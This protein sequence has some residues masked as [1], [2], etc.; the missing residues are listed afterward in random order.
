M[1]SNINDRCQKSVCGNNSN[2][3]SRVPRLRVG[4]RAY[5]ATEAGIFTFVIASKPAE[6]PTQ[7]LFQSNRGSFRRTNAEE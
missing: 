2:S 6:W 1:Y 4:D 7:P 3:V 5:F